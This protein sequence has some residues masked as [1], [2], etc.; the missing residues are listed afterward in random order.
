VEAARSLIRGRD[1]FLGVRKVAWVVMVGGGLEPNRQKQQKKRYG[2][3]PVALDE[4]VRL[5]K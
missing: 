2:S 4:V 1:F 5:L 3:K